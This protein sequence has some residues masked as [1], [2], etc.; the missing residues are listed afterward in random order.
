MI[1]TNKKKK[2]RHYTPSVNI[3]RDTGVDINYIATPNA[4]QVFNQLIN[5]YKTGWRSF[6]IVGAYGIGKS[7]FL[8]ALQKQLTG[9]KIYFPSKQSFEGAKYVI[10][11]FIG[12]YSSIIDSFAL[13]F[14][15]HKRK[16]Y[17]VKE[18]IQA[19][20]DAYNSAKK[21][22]QGLIILIDELGKYLE[23]AAKNNPE[24][25]LYFLQQLSEFINNT[26]RDLLLVTTLHQ[27]FNGYSRELTPRQKTEWD[28]V[29]GRLKELT[30]NEPVE[31]LLLLAS[32]RLSEL[33]LIS[34]PTGFQILF[35]EIKRANAFLLKDYFSEIYAEKLLPFDMVS[36]PMMT[37][38][39]QKYGQNERSLF[40]FI[41]S[42]DPHG[43][44]DFLSKKKPYYNLSS[45]FD[46]LI[47]NYYSLLSTKYNPH[48]AQWS[49][50]KTALDQAEVGY[51]G[52]ID[53]AH[54]LIKTIGLLNI[55][56]NSSVKIDDQFLE[57]YGKYSLGIKDPKATIS[58]L[59]GLR[60][61]RF[62]KHLSKYILFEGTDLDIELAIDEAGNL[63]EKVT[64]VVDHLNQY[65]DFPFILA[66]ASYY[67][68]GTPR[69]FSFQLSEQPVAPTPSGEV[70]GVINLI[71]S[72]KV[73]TAEIINISKTNNEA[74][75]Y[76]LY[77]N[78]AEI[79]NLIFEIK[80]I[81]RVKEDHVEDRVATRELEK[82]LQHQINLLNHY[83]LGSLYT[84]G[85]VRWFKGGKEV[86]ITD[87]RNFNRTLSE[88]CDEIYHGTPIY[89]NEM[90]N[91]TKLSG[92]ILA[93]R[94]NFL[95]MLAENS[96]KKD[97]GFDKDKFPPEKTI[98]LSLLKEPGIHREEDGVYS[99]GAPLSEDSGLKGLWEECSRFLNSTRESK[100]S[101]S[102]LI[103][104]LQHKPFKLKQGFIEFWIS[105]FLFAHKE[106]YA[107]FH[108]DIYVPYLPVETLELLLRDPKEYSIKKFDID[109]VNLKLFNSYRTLLNQSQKNKPTSETFIQ[110]IRPLLTFY[111]NLPNY[112]KHTKRLSKT[113]LNI[114]AAIASSKDPEDTFFSQFP[115][116]LGY[117]AKELV[118]DS[119]KLE[120]YITQL[121]NALKEIRISYDELV[122]RIEFFLCT[123]ITSSNSYPEYKLS[124]KNRFL[125]IKRHLLLPY[126]NT[127]ITRI[128]SE[129]PDNKTWLSSLCYACINK[130]LD[131]LTDEEE[132]MFC[133][134]LKDLIHELDNLSELSEAGFDES[135]EIAFKLEVTSF[136]QGLQKNLVRLP[137]SKNKELIQQLSQIKAKL[138][139]DRQLN[140][141]TLSKLLEELLHDEKS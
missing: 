106:D 46:Y 36:A 19:I 55:F 62:V 24:K 37:L 110:T 94:R 97:L 47:H 83:V 50:I 122:I 61:I 84:K 121:Q 100:R 4:S 21:K 41:E 23:F 92:P 76:G 59:K 98:Y 27:G 63:V 28:K 114:R 18:I 133:D 82:I 113:A 3:V 116:S 89:K 85:R 80:K 107:L 33:K 2:S 10:K 30:F 22:K 20:G 69:F 42:N 81:K 6:T 136:V 90:V 67:K 31:Q 87:Q 86:T 126:Q 66:K 141:A 74:V 17:T 128:Y 56:S 104:M 131:D 9:E 93:A 118:S 111:R 78:T 43:L 101:V 112:S 137:I 5:G 71:F 102:E 119:S 134:K 115:K 54:Q 34:K 51:E 35:N 109:G 99:L 58:K 65:F 48:Y 91:K 129:V 15:D 139:P 25:E 60:I 123:E 72:E 1:T 130:S 124:L 39:L 75:L 29:S 95:N 32:E 45:V 77:T 70:D 13:E 73:K 88:I 14:L 7:S 105:V 140:I 12:D 26:E 68:T 108:E 132:N 96:S 117:T 40:S 103:Q 127:F 79:R 135:K 11:T 16:T 52:K 53:D 125:N 49:S 138:G 38:A 44:S 8:W 64:N 57:Q 120:T